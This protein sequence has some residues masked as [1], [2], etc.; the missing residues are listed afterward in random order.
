L[1]KLFFGKKGGG[2]PHFWILK[3]ERWARRPFFTFFSYKILQ[4]FLFFIL[5]YLDFIL[6]KNNHQVIKNSFSATAIIV[7]NE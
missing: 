2:A 4:R 1:V 6:T 5:K 7:N 3:N